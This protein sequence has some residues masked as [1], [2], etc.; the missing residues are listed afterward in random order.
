MPL[1]TLKEN[2]TLEELRQWTVEVA[3]T[4]NKMETD[5]ETKTAR[6]QELIN[7]NNKLFAKVTSKKEDD[8]KENEEKE[9]PLCLDKETFEKLSEKDIKALNELLE[10]EDE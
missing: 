5:L 2:A 6:E 4:Y 8:K 1:P 9:I 3:D 10:G 7:Y